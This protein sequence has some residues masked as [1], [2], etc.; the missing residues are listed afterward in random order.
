MTMNIRT[1]DVAEWEVELRLDG[2]HRVC[3]CEHHVLLLR[4]GAVKWICW[5][6]DQ[7]V[8]ALDLGE[9]Q[10]NA[11]ASGHLTAAIS[12]RSAVDT[13]RFKGTLAIDELSPFVDPSSLEPREF[14][15]RFLE[16]SGIEANSSPVGKY[17]YAMFSLWCLLRLDGLDICKLRRG[18]HLCQRK[19][20]IDMAVDAYPARPSLEGLVCH[21]ALRWRSQAGES[22]SDRLE[23]CWGG[24]IRRLVEE[25]LEAQS[26]PA[27]KGKAKAKGRVDS[28]DDGY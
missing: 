27:P 3:R 8:I 14:T 15:A 22:A 12:L 4:A 16:R 17:C 11:A 25:E 5:N 23:R 6:S 28:S 24:M 2:P 26:R 18:E 21:A 13:L 20:Q 1:C 9:F 7:N 10:R 19:L